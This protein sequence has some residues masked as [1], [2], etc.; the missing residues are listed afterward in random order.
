MSK[1][2][3]FNEHAAN[4]DLTIISSNK[5]GTAQISGKI[6]PCPKIGIEGGIPPERPFDISVLQ[7]WRIFF[8]RFPKMAPT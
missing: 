8:T 7:R 3:S 2:P 1:K 5:Q 6:E 4:Y